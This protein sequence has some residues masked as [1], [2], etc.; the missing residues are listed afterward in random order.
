MRKTIVLLFIIPILFNFFISAESCPENNIINKM[1]T[2]MDSF[3]AVSPLDHSKIRS[4]GAQL[5]KAG[6]KLTVSLSNMEGLSIKKLVN[7]FVLP[8]TKKEQFILD[9][10]L[11]NGKNEVVAGTYSGASGYGKPFWAFAEVKLH[12]GEKGVIVSLG[13][14]EGE[15]IITKMTDKTVCGKF[16]LRSK[17]GSKQ[18]SMLSGKFNTKLERSAW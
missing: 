7:D 18:S 6:T 2:N 8:I 15:V 4:S 3:N 1:A 5:N 12:K 11:R 9:I 14:R 17:K 10:E 13:I 16:E